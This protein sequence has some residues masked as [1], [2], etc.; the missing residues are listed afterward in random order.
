M[1]TDWEQVE[2]AVFSAVATGTGL[3]TVW[4]NQAELV[5]PA[6]NYVTLTKPAGSGGNGLTVVHTRKTDLLQPAGQEVEL[7]VS[8]LNEFSVRVQAFTAAT[9]GNAAALA[10][11]G[12]MRLRLRLESVRAQL[13]AAG[14]VLVEV[15]P[16]RDLAA[17]TGTRWQG[18]AAV[19]LRFRLVETEAERVGYIATAEVTTAVT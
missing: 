19:E 14:L 12:N 16:A 13:A 5:Q 3:E 17:I 11:A 10:V 9:T 2:N 6:G 8:A 15:G 1:A 7:R 18:R 4:S